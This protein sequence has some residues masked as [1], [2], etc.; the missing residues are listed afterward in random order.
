MADWI[1]CELG[2][3]T[4]EEKG[5]SEEAAAE[6]AAEATVAATAVATAVATTVEL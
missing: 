1:D 6:A 3:V 4:T 5:R 2:P